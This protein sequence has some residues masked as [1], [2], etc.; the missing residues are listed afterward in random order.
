MGELLKS[1]EQERPLGQIPHAALGMLPPN[2]TPAQTPDPYAAAV[3][4]AKREYPRFKNMPLAL[5]A[6]KPDTND[7]GTSETYP[8]NEDNNPR[9]GHVTVELRNPRAINDPSTWAPIVALEAI[10]GL[11][12]NDPTYQAF[13]NQMVKSMTPK[14]L[15]MSRRMYERDKQQYGT[16][17]SFDKW[18]ARVNA[19]EWIRGLLF[20]DFFKKW[21]PDEPP[22][23]YT[24][25]QKQL[26]R[27][28]DRYL[29]GQN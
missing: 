4:Q 3:E 28:I 26:G 27:Q 10:H 15:A 6:G 2:P 13:T 18:N 9:P 5:I 14:Q 12:E 29:R 22:W 17:E 7:T 24:P 8:I 1:Q 19:Q 16:T 20:Q 11:Q 25:E 21:E 23:P